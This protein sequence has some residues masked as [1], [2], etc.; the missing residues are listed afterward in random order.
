MGG[1]GIAWVGRQ[2]GYGAVGI[3]DAGRVAWTPLAHDLLG[4][5]P[6]AGGPPP[7]PHVLTGVSGTAA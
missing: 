5:D 6:Q 2:P 4:L 3:T 1:R 7:D